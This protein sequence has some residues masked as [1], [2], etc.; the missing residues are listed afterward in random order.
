M[1]VRVKRAAVVAIVLI[2]AGVSL[3]L[4]PHTA[5][6]APVGAIALFGGAVL[7]S[8]ISWWLP[9]AIMA[10]SDLFLGLH[11]TILFTWGAFFLVALLGM[12]LRH[13]KN[14]LHVPFGALGAAIIFFIVSNFGVWVEGKLYPHTWQ[15]L[16]DCYVMATPFFKTTLLA[17]LSYS[18]V[19]FSAYALAVQPE[20]LRTKDRLEQQ[21]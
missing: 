17:D 16:I 6:F 4:L 13:Q 18:I 8:R 15:G 20:K 9:L 2:I 3:R 5:N 14:W 21:A 12:S 19:L 10:I 7:S 11:G 1:E